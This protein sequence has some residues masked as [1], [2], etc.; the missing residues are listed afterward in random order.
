MAQLLANLNRNQGR[1]A[2]SYDAARAFRMGTFGLFLYGPYQHYWYSAL[3]RAM[4][5]RTLA[6]FGVKV[7]MNQL[8]LAP[9][10]VG[11]VFAWNLA[12]QGRLGEWVPKVQADFLPTIVTGWKFWVPAATVNFV[13]VPLPQQVLYMSTCGLV[14]TAFLSYSSSLGAEEQQPATV[15]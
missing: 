14:W 9:L 6:N 1:D 4:P 10:V 7:A 2:A 8:L 15:S 13:A 3:D 5:A 12:L 11:G